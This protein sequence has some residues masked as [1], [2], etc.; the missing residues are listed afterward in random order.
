MPVVRVL[1]RLL[2]GGAMKRR[3]AKCH[4][5]RPQYI[6]NNR[7]LCRECY[8]QYQRE[9]Q[10]YKYGGRNIGLRVNTDLPDDRIEDLADLLPTMM[11]RY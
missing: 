10:N 5:D 4:P 8:L 9:Y 3:M 2:H 6:L 11:G 7:P 1:G